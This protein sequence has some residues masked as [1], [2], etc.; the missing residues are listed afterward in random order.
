MVVGNKVVDHERITGIRESEVEGIALYEV[1]DRL[2][3]NVWL[4]SDE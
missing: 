2:I 4:Y 1:C 3:R